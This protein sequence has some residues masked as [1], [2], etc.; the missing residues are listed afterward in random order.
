MEVESALVVS[1]PDVAEAAVV[2]RP[3][4]IKGTAIAAFVTP[5]RTVHRRLRHQS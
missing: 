2:G 3:D 4:D 5:R 1:H